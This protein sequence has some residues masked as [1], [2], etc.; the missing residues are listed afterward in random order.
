MSF[1]YTSGLVKDEISLDL[2]YGG[3]SMQWWYI[4]SFDQSGQK[5]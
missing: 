3:W 2:I 4:A 1:S 5:I